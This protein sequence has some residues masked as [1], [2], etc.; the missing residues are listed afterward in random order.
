MSADKNKKPSDYF[1][2]TLDGM[3]KSLKIGL[4]DWHLPSGKVIYSSE[5]EAIAGYEEGELDQDVTSWSNSLHPDDVESAEK[6]IDDHMS[7]NTSSYETEFRMYRKD[8]SIIWAQDR[9][10][11]VEWDENGTPIRMI[12]ILQDISRLKE[13]EEE[14]IAR[15]AQLEYVANMSGLA[16]WEWDV[17]NDSIIYHDQYYNLLGYKSEEINGSVDKWTALLHPDDKD[18]TLKALQ[19]YINGEATSYAHE[20]RMRTSTGDYIWTLDI[21]CVIKW[22]ENE[23]PT[24]LW[25]GHLNIDKLKRV[26][27]TL[28]EKI[29]VNDA[30]QIQ[31]QAEIKKVVKNLEA[32]QL[33]NNKMLDASPYIS[34]VFDADFELV[35]CNL[36]AVEYFNFPSKEEFISGFEAYF[37]KA[38]PPFQPGGEVS[39]TLPEILQSAADNTYINSEI[40]LV[41]N[42]TWVPFQ[43][44]FQRIKY[45]DSYIIIGY[46]TDLLSIKEAKNELIRQDILLYAGN[47]IA[48]MLLAS[49]DETKFNDTLYET[50]KTLGTCTNVTRA[51][52][53]KVSLVNNTPNI[54][55]LKSWDAN[56]DYEN[57]MLDNISVDFVKDHP[58]YKII[59]NNEILICHREDF[60]PFINELLLLDNVHTILLTP[61]FMQ[62]EFWG[63][64]GLED[65]V[66]KRNFTSSEQNILK[67]SAIMIASAIMRNEMTE[68]LIAAK[69]LAIES[70]K[71]KNEF[72]SRMSHEIRTPMN[73]I[74]GMTTIA[75]RS[76][77]I[78]NINHCLDRIETASKQLLGII[79]DILDIAKI[80]ANKFEIVPNE[81]E[82][83]KVI[84]DIFNMMQ[85]KMDE[86]NLEF[87]FG[88][89]YIFDRFVICD[90]LRLSQVII[91]LLSNAVKFTPDNGKISLKIKILEECNDS[92]VLR[93]E[94]KDTGIG[95]SDEQKSKLFNSFE[96][97]DGSITRKYGGSGLGLAICKKIVTLMGG[98]IYIESELGNGSCFIFEVKIKFGGKLRNNTANKHVFR[99]L[100]ILVLDDSIDILTY[101]GNVFESF[102]LPCDSVMTSEEAYKMIAKSIKKSH[103]YD[104]ILIDS[105]IPDTDIVDTA[106]RIKELTD[107]SIIVMMMAVAD[108]SE[109]EEKLKE[110]DISEF[111]PKPILPSVLYNKIIK[112]TSCSPIIEPEIEDFEDETHNWS[113]KYIL[114]AEDVEINKEIIYTIL[115]DTC[116]NIDHAENGKIAVEMF[117]ETP[118]KYD[119]ILMDVQMPEMDGLEA[120]RRI[121]K[122]SCKNANEI[123][124]IAM[125]ANAFKEDMMECI[126]AGMNEH[127]SKPINLNEFI[128]KLAFYLEI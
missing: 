120:T 67:S 106:R 34:L 70:A 1:T 56:G 6:A 83:E 89:D 75:K 47:N 5:W 81:F 128:N 124:I 12:G 45:N 3:I 11:I 20:V 43:A 57:I 41:I 72:L 42:D 113:N 17:V 33:L 39:K 125:T 114:I 99:D 37:E 108:S 9:G 52:L 115:E 2:S 103:P 48:S 94:V 126:A 55:H 122:S 73:A 4:W 79:N 118:D 121:R 50:L 49:Y 54:V 53:W 44:I 88:S 93:V 28:Q 36:Y 62:G 68:N 74:I 85:I 7:G 51:Y 31:L 101:I 13:T 97:A 77:D 71:A 32:T 66:N 64:M 76:S 16:I 117:T 18:S 98:D 63:C 22:D 96:Q 24:R 29:S 127:I 10:H 112:L 15:S 27:V 69:E 119:L 82:F 35:N 104:I 107:E 86:K 60:D 110:H 30:Y 38:N 92:A 90:E 102:S 26:E 91:N 84:Q 109:L 111:I 19:A 123:P 78:E 14:L 65:C 46:M 61:I 21:A 105:Q 25:G 58:W 87:F 80:E 40:E 59:T 8:G 116:V 95:I 100:K 23:K